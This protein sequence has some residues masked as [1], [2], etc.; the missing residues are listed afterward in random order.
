MIQHWTTRPARRE[1]AM[2]SETA[3][4]VALLLFV[5]FTL[6][7]VPLLSRGVSQDCPAGI[8]AIAPPGATITLCVGSEGMYQVQMEFPEKH[9]GTLERLSVRIQRLM[10]VDADTLTRALSQSIQLKDLEMAEK[11]S[12][13]GLTQRSMPEPKARSDGKA[14][15]IKNTTPEEDRPPNISYDC[16]YVVMQGD[17]LLFIQASTTS[18]EIA[19]GWVEHVKGHLKF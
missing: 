14:W 15:Y 19:D 1:R 17:A 9:K 4:W 5:L 13:H 2:N 18:K 7:P 12:P 11:P 10:D 6:A 3:R 16:S 8:K